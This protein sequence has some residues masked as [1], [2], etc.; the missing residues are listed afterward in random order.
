MKELGQPGD[1]FFNVAG[2][3]PLPTLDKS[4][5]DSYRDWRDY[6]DFPQL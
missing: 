6:K 2:N 1:W 4:T 3:A 5:I